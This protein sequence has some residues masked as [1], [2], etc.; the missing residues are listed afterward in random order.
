MTVFGGEGGDTFNVYSNKAVLRLEGESGNDN[1]VIRAFIAKDSIIANGGGDDDYFEYNINAPVSINGGLGFDTVV[2][3]GTEM[4]DAFIITDEGIFGAGLNIRLDGVE[5]AIE[6]DGLE[7]DD[8]FYIMSTRD[9]VITTVIGGLGSDT[10]NIA[11]DVTKTV[12]SQDLN[13]RSS[14]I[15]QGTTSNE[16]NPYDKLLVDGVAVAIADVTQGKVLITESDGYTELLEDSGATDSYTISLVRPTAALDSATVAYLTVSAGISSSYDKRL[17][18]LNIADPHEADSVLVS[19]DNGATWQ[20]AAVLTFTTEE[21]EV[22]QTV[23]VKAAHDDT[24]EG[25]RKVMISHSLMVVSPSEAD[26]AAFNA[27]AIPNVE[28]RVLDDDLGTLL[29]RESDNSTRVLEGSATSEISDTYQVKLSVI[30]TGQVTVNLGFDSS[31]VRV[32]EGDMEITSLTFG[33]GADEWRTITVKAVQDTVRE[34]TGIARITHSFDDATTDP[35]YASALD[36]ELDV[37]VFDDDS[38]RVL[39]T[40]SDGSTRVVMNGEGDDYTLRLVSNPG[41]PVYVNL[42][43]DGQTVFTG[44]QTVGLSDARLIEDRNLG[45]AQTLTV[46]FAANGA[47]ADTITMTGMSWTDAG[48]SIGTLFSINGGTTLK[49][50][51]ITDTMIGDTVVSTLTLTTGGDVP[52]EGTQT[53]SLQRKTFAVVFDSTNWWQEVSVSIEADSNFVADPDQLYVRHEPVREHVVNSISGPLIIE[54]GVAEGKDR[55]IRPAV[56]LPTEATGLPKDISVL[57]DETQQADRLNVF[58]DSSTADDQGWMTSVELSNEVV[59]LDNAINISGLGMRPGVDGKSTGMDVD[60]SENPDVYHDWVTF[61]GGITFDDIEITEIMLGQGNDTFTIDATSAGTT[62]AEEFVVT[63]VHGGGNSYLTDANGDYF[64]VEGNTTNVPVIGGDTITVTGA[65]SPLVIYGDTAQDGRRYDARPDLNI[66]TGNAVTFANSGNDIIDASAISQSVTIYGGA[67]NDTIRGSQGGDHLA[68]GSG[69]DVIYGGSGNDHIYGDSGFNL[70]FNVQ[71][72]AED[73]AV[74]ERVLTV[75]T[76]NESAAVTSD[77]LVAGT[78]K[79]YGGD[80]DDVIFG[81]MGVV[82]QAYLKLLSTGNVTEIRS[83]RFSN[84]EADHIYGGNGNDIILGGNKG[85]EIDAGEGNNIVLGDEGWIKY[86]TDGNLAD[87]DIIESLSTTMYGGVD[88]ITTGAG[89]DIIIGGRYGDTIIAN[90]GDNLVIGDSGRITAASADAPQFG[91]TM[92]YGLIE[93]IASADG[94]D[95]TITT[96][97]GNDIILGGQ[98]GD[99]IKADYA[100]TNEEEQELVGSGT[101]IVIGDNGLLDYTRADREPTAAGADTDPSDLDLV[102]SLDEVIGGNDIITTGDGS[103]LV[104]GGAGSDRIAVNNGNN[105]VLGDSG[106]ITAA[107]IDGPQLAGLPLTIGEILTTADG[108]GGSDTITAGS[109]NDILVGGTNDSIDNSETEVDERV[110]T[111]IAGEGNNIVLG[112]SGRIDYARFE[113]DGAVP[114]ADTNPSDIDLIEST[115]TTAYGG[116]DH[117]TTGSGSDIIIGGRFGDII[118]AN[119][120]DNLVIGDSG[121]I[122]AANASAPQ[123]GVAMTY[124]LIETIAFGDGG[125]DTIMT[126]GGN[127]IILGGHVGD[128]IDAGEGNNIVLGDDGKID[129]TRADRFTTA[130]ADTDPS[131]IDLIESLSTMAAGGVDTITTGAGNDIII[132]GRYGDTIIANAGDNLVIGDSGRITAA[133][134]N[135]PQF[136]VTMTYGLI[137]TIAFSDGGVDNI[138][139]LGGRDIVLGGHEGDIINAGEGNNIVIGDDGRIDYTRADRLTTAG[140]DTDPSDI[141]LIESLSTTGAGG[142]DTITTGAGND[143]IIGGRYGDTIIANAGDNLVIGDS[144]RITAASADA[145]QFGVAMTYGLIETIAFGDGGVDNITTLGGRDIVLGGHAGDIIDAGE[146][147]NIV[148]GDDG[149]IDYTRADRAASE[150]G[151]DFNPADIDLIESLSTTDAGGADTITTGAGNDIIIGGRYG[152][153][154]I[155]NAGDN[156]VIGDSGRI[157]ADSDSTTPWPGQLM[158]VGKIETITPK[159]GGADT[160]TALGGNDI[161]LGGTEG[162]EIHAGDG[163]DIVFGDQGEIRTAEGNGNHVVTYGTEAVPWFEGYYYMAT[164]IHDDLA[165]AGDLIYGEGGRDYILGQQGAD[166]IFGGAGDDDIYGGHNVAGGHDTGD[167]I[168]GG[169]GNDVIVGDNASIQG[170]DDYTS[171]RFR[172]LSGTLMYDNDGAALVTGDSKSD[173]NRVHARTVVL[174]DSSHSPDADTFGNDLIAGGADDDVIFGQLGDDTLHGDGQISDPEFTATTLDH[175]QYTLSALSEPIPGSDIGGDDYV[176]GNGGNDTIY[177]GLGQDDLIGGNSSLFGLNTPEQRPDGFDTIYGGNADMLDRNHMGDESLNGHARDADMILGDNGNIYRLVGVNIN[178]I[179]QTSGAS[180]VGGVVATFNGFLAFNYDN[181]SNDLKIIAR[182]A[183]LIDYTPGGPDY[184]LTGA[185]TDKGAGDEIHGESG[186]DFIYG[187]KGND[188]LYGEGQDDDIIGGYGNDWISGGTG[189]DGIL[190]DDGRIY[191]SRNSSAYGEPLYGI[192]PLL[193]KDPNT[194]FNNGDV[195]NEFIYTPGKIQQS[196]IN[197]A[198]ELKKSVNLTP[199]NLDPTGGPGGGIQD[200]LFRPSQAND[201]IYGGW[202]N[203]FLHGGAG[204]D[205]ISGAEAP[206]AFDVREG[207]PSYDNAFNPGDI[208]GYSQAKVWGD[209]AK[210]GEFAWYDEYNPLK[211]IEGFLLNF[212]AT[213]GPAAGTKHTDGDD[214]IFGDLGNDWIVGGTGRDHLYGGYGDD[215]LNADDDLETAGGL[216]NIPD[217][218]TTYEDIAYGGAGRDVLIANTGGDRLIDWAGEFNSYIVPFA[219]YGM[220]TISRTVQPQLPEY[221]YALSMSDGVDMTRA[222]DTGNDAA[223]NGE[224]DG[225]LG[226]VKQKDA[227][228]QDQTGAPADPQAGNIAGGRRDVLRSASFNTGTSDMFA[229]DSGIWTVASG[230]Y[231]VAPERL[232]GDALAVFNVD[233]YIP[234]YFEMT[235]TIRAV[236]PTGGYNAN[237]YL[238]FDYQSATDFKFAGINVSTSKLEIGYRDAAGWHVVLQKPYNTALKADTDYNLL[239]ALNGSTATLVV[240]NKVTLTHTFATRVD[241]D[242]F[243]YFLNEGMVGLGAN[244]A[245]AQIDNVVVQRIAPETT[246]ERTVGF[247]GDSADQA[248]FKEIFQ[249]PPAGWSINEGRYIGENSINLVNMSIDPAYLL[250]L[251]ASLKTGAKGGFVFDYYGSQDY[252]FVTVSVETGQVLI[253]HSTAKAGWVVDAAWSN[254]ALSAE[255]DYS[256]GATLMGNTVSVTFN[257]QGVLSF[258]FNALVTDGQFGLLAHNGG[259]SF[260]TFAVRTDDPSFAETVTPVILPTISVTDASVMEGAEGSQAVVAL[261]FTLSG[262]ADVSVSVDYAT[263]NGTATAGEDYLFAA[264]TLTFDPGQTRKEVTFLVY[265]D[266]LLES[267]ET[268]TVEL[269]NPSGAAIADGAGII[270]I[271]N[272]DVGTEPALPGLS[273]ADVTVLEGDRTNKTKV[274]VTV[275][276]SQASAAPVSVRLSTED[277]T[278]MSGSDYVAT[279][280]TITFA[281]GETTKQYTLTVNG[282]RIGEADEWFGVRLSGANGATV[283]DDFGRVTILNDD[284][285]PMAAAAAPTEITSVEALTDEMLAPIAEEAINRWT[286]AL[287]IDETTV[288][289]L[290]AV[291][292]QIADFVGL[293]LGLTESNTIY[294][295]ADAAGHGWYV[296]QT[297]W[298]NMEFGQADSVAAGR[299]DLLTVVMH[300]LGHMLG[301]RDIVAAVDNIMNEELSAGVRYLPSDLSYA[302]MPSAP[303]STLLHFAPPSNGIPSGWIFENGNI[304]EE[305]NSG[306]WWEWLRQRFM[307]R[308]AYDGLPGLITLQKG[309]STESP[310]KILEKEMDMPVRLV[311]TDMAGRNG[312]GERTIDQG[313]PW[314]GDFLINGTKKTDPNRDIEISIQR[315]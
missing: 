232:G 25:E 37:K 206:T 22:P 77:G 207:Y 43:G 59:S 32:Y 20:R 27:V 115:S 148:L 275:T 196:T 211:K 229:V 107:S 127:D 171:P 154:I 235:A 49:V 274:N 244:N 109:G 272:D 3:I 177:G 18:A 231:Q 315:L 165:G 209:P 288:A 114:G 162:D 140:A 221:L 13:G 204:D 45:D 297:P 259:V 236:K 289:E 134:A 208:L 58:N 197:V 70:T 313:K 230:R 76:A 161:I 290:Q 287:A 24:L 195:L 194:R 101:N 157:T 247:S 215:L 73:E 130:G 187:M 124:G 50:N 44:A 100:G 5:E 135:A 269:S 98:G 121:R 86:N 110:E 90:A 97:I 62:G 119:D 258:A 139:T 53:V 238:I 174:Y 156:L 217:T 225:E 246:M 212:D 279:G 19:I 270:T 252:K 46:E 122:T 182:A 255:A 181:Y 94:G 99:T 306:N 285:Y 223:R 113:R 141:D 210:A 68:G 170:T 138:T 31:Q 120:G 262:A 166:V 309:G 2:A 40:E 237:A 200:P 83:E 193:D 15:N 283:A 48:F 248:V 16:S 268:F 190:G 203:D 281:A 35:V 12:I 173:P 266:S 226:L 42:Y 28:V 243:Q 178:Q 245:K 103:D 23:L 151:A 233:K 52:A 163:V 91:V 104:I 186:D 216:N 72:N 41:A 65:D 175:E 179:A 159:D 267:D 126:L 293:T 300:E 265:G 201:I 277:G 240:Q 17:D 146:G 296:D 185:A 273:I 81:D 304:Y 224:P 6:V 302:T 158:S 80:G 111:I 254:A 150:P 153:T 1:F 132:G 66:F 106:R 276:L 213:E 108:I 305:A 241:A 253:G 295:D 93:T 155:A 128:I 314:L 63:V 30:P 61:P 14:V 142:A 54:G 310:V 250:E 312:D 299:M 257:N 29:I 125:A 10:F 286:E 298:D 256:L 303:M 8:T 112:D 69:N 172:A 292:F 96:G 191:T 152:D 78:D 133:S 64:D 234:N 47:D 249:A 261:T 51:N 184:D 278:A 189:D 11:G 168:D 92:T 149:K 36:V 282:D 117:I 260:D 26:K 263:R 129:Y 74:V 202:G 7:G 60:I 219:P 218:D 55:S 34:N 160:I 294:I 144:G 188:V 205:A 4:A 75:V 222:A 228:W 89:N 85:D 105:L 95:D 39:V 67:G 169:T 242:G 227:A 167:I 180:I 280:T 87:I 57:T 192:V 214:A 131:D 38:A 137:E 198:G 123:F 118:N 220:A 183:E 164:N 147:N 145:P 33:A 56:M 199:F 21:W 82:D 291:N 311:V 307:G 88:T 239:L 251:G 301:Y 264:G 143:I 116:V 71:K 102:M 284:G 308:K 84:G 79:I 136:G 271:L 176:E 9:K